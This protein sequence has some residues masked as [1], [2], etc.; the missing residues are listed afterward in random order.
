MTEAVKIFKANLMGKFEQ[1]FKNNWED[2]E[3]SQSLAIL[4]FSKLQNKSDEKKWRPTAQPVENQVLPLVY[5]KLLHKKKYILT[6]LMFQNQLTAELIPQ[7]EQFRSGFKELITRNRQIHVQIET[8]GPNLARAEEAIKFI[9][10]ELAS[11]TSFEAGVE[12]I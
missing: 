5:K 1:K 12:Q 9:Q 6:Q 2:L 8:D 10:S 3:L 4:E 11:K 7:V